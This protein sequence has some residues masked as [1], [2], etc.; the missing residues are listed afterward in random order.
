MSK[1]GSA[2][3]ANRVEWIFNNIPVVYAGKYIVTWS[4]DTNESSAEI[5]GVFGPIPDGTTRD[6]LVDFLME[7]DVY[8]EIT[9]ITPLFLGKKEAL[10]WRRQAR[11]T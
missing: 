9:D 3:S 4:Q 2:M 5:V 1:K 8:F 7:D 6:V 10:L 11:S